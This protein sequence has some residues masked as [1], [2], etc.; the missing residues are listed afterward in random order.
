MAA[1]RIGGIHRDAR[2][3]SRPTSRCRRWKQSTTKGSTAHSCH[4]GELGTVRVRARATRAVDACRPRRWYA[5]RPGPA[6]AV[7]NGADHSARCSRRE[8]SRT[9]TLDAA[10]VL[11]LATSGAER[12]LRSASPTTIDRR[13]VSRFLQSR[14]RH[15]EPCKFRE[16]VCAPFAA[17]TWVA[18]KPRNSPAT[19]FAS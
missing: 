12:D 6:Y 8:R 3:R 19:A 5:A 2:P 1:P 14:A 4:Q 11:L 17:E 13:E 16:R 15:T 7:V 9:Q 18:R 10:S